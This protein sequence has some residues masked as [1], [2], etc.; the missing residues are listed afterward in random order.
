[1]NN[2]PVKEEYKQY[3][4]DVKEVDKTKL[5]RSIIHRDLTHDNVLVRDNKVVAFIDF[6][7]AHND[8]LAYDL[9]II[10]AKFV[11]KRVNKHQVS[12]FMNHYNPPITLDENEK[13]AIYYFMKHRFLTA[14]SW[15]EKH[16]R[17]D[18]SIYSGVSKWVDLTISQY[19]A[20]SRIPADEFVKL[21]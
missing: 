3:L 7:D 5:K 19:K 2:F 6:D 10:L 20:L 4:K 16:R 17:Q 14:M 18:S 13:T 11:R 12:L 1:M 21:L 8:F 15:A 9:A